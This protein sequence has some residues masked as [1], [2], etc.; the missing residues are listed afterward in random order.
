[1]ISNF[2]PENRAIYE[3]MS[4]NLVKPERPQV[5]YR[6]ALH[7]GLVRLGLPRVMVE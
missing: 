7:A 6:G 2:F 5:E 1:M 3:I 4:K